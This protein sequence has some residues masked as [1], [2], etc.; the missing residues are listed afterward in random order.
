MEKRLG[1]N[2]MTSEYAMLCM[3]R[4]EGGCRLDGAP[5][6]GLCAQW[7]TADPELITNL[8]KGMVA[9]DK[10]WMTRRGNAVAA[11]WGTRPGPLGAQ[12]R[13]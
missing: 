2:I 3:N 6:K 7:N 13:A 10:K 4:I 8:G 11:A 1:G 12:V 9:D 5:C